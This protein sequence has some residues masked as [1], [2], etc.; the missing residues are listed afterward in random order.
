MPI[1][2]LVRA[3][4]TVNN[5]HISIFY[6]P[7]EYSHEDITDIVRKGR[8]KSAKN[9]SV[10]RTEHADFIK[11]PNNRTNITTLPITYIF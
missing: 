9:I 5:S 2:Q 7:L 11:D 6:D 1:N 8:Y 3:D 10:V 4:Y